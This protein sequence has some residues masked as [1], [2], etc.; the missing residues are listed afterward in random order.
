MPNIPQ[1]SLI[2]I[3][4]KRDLNPKSIV[5]ILDEYRDHDARL[6]MKWIGQIRAA[7]HIGISG[8]ME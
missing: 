6:I 7:K 2:V 3:T 1:I 8:L 4:N 5:L